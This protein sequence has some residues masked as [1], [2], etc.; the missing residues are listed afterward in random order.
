MRTLTI[1]TATDTVTVSFAEIAKSY[2][3]ESELLSDSG[4]LHYFLCENDPGDNYTVEF[5]TAN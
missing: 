3:L 5:K 4:A 2:G 1:K